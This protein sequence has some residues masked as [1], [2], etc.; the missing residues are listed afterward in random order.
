MEAQLIGFVVF[1]GN[2][3]AETISKSYNVAAGGAASG[4]GDYYFTLGQGG[5]AASVCMAEI[6]PSNGAAAADITTPSIIHTSATLKRI[7]FRDK[8]GALV[9]PPNAPI[10]VTFYRMPPLA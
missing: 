2:A 6:V 5:A 3:G 10:V 8:A 4:V 7:Q 9:D 1:V